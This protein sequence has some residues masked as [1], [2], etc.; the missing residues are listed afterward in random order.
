MN[1]IILKLATPIAIMIAS[2]FLS[3]HPREQHYD[4]EQRRKS[5]EIIDVKFY[6]LSFDIDV[7]N[8]YLE[9]EAICHFDVLIS[10]DTFYLDLV[11]EL[12]VTTVFE[13]SK[14]LNY[15]Q[16]DNKLGFVFSERPSKNELKKVKIIYA[17]N[18]QKTGN[19]GIEKGLIFET[20]GNDEP[21]IATLSTP[22]LAHYW[23]PCKDDISDKA[24]SV[25]IDI[26]IP[27]DTINNQALTTVSNGKLIH[28][29]NLRNDKKLFRWQHRYPIASCY[30]FFAVSN[31]KIFQ[32]TYKDKFGNEFPLR[33][34]SFPED[35]ETSL[36]QV[37]NVEKALD[38]FTDLYGVYPFAKEGFGLAQIGFYSGI[39][40]QTCPIVESISDR[41]LYTLIHELSHAWFANS[42]TAKTWQD[43]WLHEGFATYSEALF[44]EK[45]R[46]RKGYLR[47][48][49][50]FEHL[51]AGSIFAEQTDNPFEVFS[52]IV[53]NKGAYVLHSLRGFVGDEDFF[54]I[55][56]NYYET[57]QYKNV[58]TNDFKEICELI[59]G[60][61]LETFFNQWVYGTGH[62]QYVYSY[63]QNP[64]TL[65]IILNIRQAQVVKTKTV[66]DA[67]IQLYLDFAYR[68]S[69]MT[70]EN[71]EVF[72]KYTIP[73]TQKLLNL[74]IDPNN[75][76][77][78]EVLIKKEIL[79]VSNNAIYEVEIIPN[80][81]GRKIDLTLK[82]AKRQ[83]ATFKLNDA[84][85]TTKMSKT[86]RTAGT[87]MLTV[88]IPRNIEG[89]HYTIIIETKF[90]R[91][92]KD[93][94]ILD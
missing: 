9:A 81:S 39:E 43:A 3:C 7:E 63:Y 56:K 45:S 35:Y 57:Y 68:D 25:F 66:Y 71:S 10:Q 11:N 14:A 83:P 42:V 31:Y 13:E 79:E 19:G 59:S 30:V 46:G 87:S 93:L 53:Y 18:F 80:L 94:M 1:H 16:A 28:E 21:V 72:Q 85:G 60:K 61:N 44:L 23:F 82:S 69:V 8:K 38:F 52:G 86:I 89:G 88:E 5:S 40:T 48:I 15:F 91:Y 6:D 50:Q 75:W 78:K 62:P 90:E 26:T 32:K 77:L 17:G 22:F 73:S 47:A 55:L 84:Y 74:E 92:F 2:I 41:R 54:K 4:L 76:I 33:F 36:L 27:N 49:N 58:S 20:H 70:I 29:I 67:P 64:K 34:Y 65:D 37:E 51:E 12:K 24:D